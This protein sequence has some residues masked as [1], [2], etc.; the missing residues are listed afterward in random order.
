MTTTRYILNHQVPANPLIAGHP[1]SARRWPDPSRYL[2]RVARELGITMPCVA[3]M[4]AV[5]ITHSILI[6]ESDKELWVEGFFTVGISNA[7]RAGEPAPHSAGVPGTINIILVTNARLPTSALVG[8]VQVATES[9]TAVLLARKVKSRSGS[10]ATGTGTDTVT[11]AVGPGPGYRFSGPHTK[12][13]E[14]LGRTVSRGIE[15]G[16]DLRSSSA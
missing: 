4:T 10:P 16:L 9:K 11:I 12:L 6:R 2:G 3:L 7:T 15:R 1:S 14:L 13:G 8:A 5:D